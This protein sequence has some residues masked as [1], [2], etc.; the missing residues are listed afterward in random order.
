MSS[1]RPSL[2]DGDVAPHLRRLSIPLVWGL[3]SLSLFYVVDTFYISRLGTL[4][5]AALGFTIPVVLFNMGIVFGL[6]VGTTSVLSR[7]YGQGDIEKFRQL[8][9][10]SLSLTVALTVAAAIVGLIFMDPIFRMMGASDDIMPL[11]HRYVS[12]WYCGFIFFGTMMVGNATFR[13]TGETGFASRM[14]IM[15]AVINLVLDPFLIFGWGPL[16]RLGLTGAAAT[17]VF[18][19]Y[20]TCMTTMY[21]LIFRKQILSV[22]VIHAGIFDSWRRI[23]HVAFPSIISNQIS[24]VSAAVITWLAS[25]FGKEAV[26]ALGVATRIENLS[27]LVFYAIGAGLSIFT[28]QNFGAGNYGRIQEATAVASRYCI[29]WGLVVAA[30]LWIFARDIPELFDGNTMVVDYAALYLHWVPISYGAMGMMIASNA[31]LNAMGRPLPA[32]FLI[33]LRA[34]V[35]YVPLAWVLREYFGFMGIIIALTLTNLAVG[36]I[37]YVWNR[38][39]AS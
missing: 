28:G 4:P 20:T 38:R 37:S 23:L 7:A 10:D 32:T 31:A 14:M 11:I 6:S 29:Y 15:Q 2:L 13:A 18:T 22:R 33:L 21:Y 8:A 3:S 27:T 9:T 24:P 16:P 1:S 25:G 35:F 12:V 36:A 26:A 30:G 19:Y 34:V 5:L 17:L 39:V